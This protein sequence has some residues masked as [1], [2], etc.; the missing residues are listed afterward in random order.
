[1]KPQLSETAQTYKLRYGTSV[2][3]SDGIEVAIVGKSLDDVAA[4]WR[5]LAPLTP[6]DPAM[7]QQVK[8]SKSDC[9]TVTN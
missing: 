3:T 9:Q 2:I 8:I 5:R 7:V 6:F 1:M 4:I